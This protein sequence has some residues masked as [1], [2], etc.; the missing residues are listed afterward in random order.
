MRVIAITGSIG[1]GKTT[2]AGLI[3]RLG[4]VVYDV[5]KWCRQL[6]YDNNFLKVIYQNFPESW[7]DGVFNKRKLRTLVF[8]DNIKLKKLEKLTHP[9]LKLK[10]LKIIHKSALCGEN[11]VFVD[12]ALLF[13]M[14]WEKYCTDIIVADAPYNV[15]KQRVMARDN[16]SETDFEKINSVQMSNED[17]ISLSDYVVNTDKS[18]GLLKA[19]L[20]VLIEEMEI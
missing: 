9:F 6:Y 14:G 1:C 13:E 4:F 15:Q 3:R 8:D 19:E 16:I 5:D 17:R 11:V 10:F 18:I 7:Q 2:I 20:A 12:V